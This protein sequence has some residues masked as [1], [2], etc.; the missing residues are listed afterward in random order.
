MTKSDRATSQ[1]NQ[2]CIVE[3]MARVRCEGAPRTTKQSLTRMVAAPLIDSFSQLADGQPETPP[4]VRFWG[5]FPHGASRTHQ[6][7]W[8]SVVTRR[9]APHIRIPAAAANNEI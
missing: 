1:L 5:Y 7:G 8:A 9:R 3:W 6:C 4:C 2:C